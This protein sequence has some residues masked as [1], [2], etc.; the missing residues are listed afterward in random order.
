MGKHLFRNFLILLFVIASQLMIAYAGL[1]VYYRNAFEYGTWIN[2]IYCTGKSVE[3]VNHELAG[4]FT[5][6]GITV[7]DKEWNAYFISAEDIAYQYDFGEAL[8]IYLNRQN[9]W[10][11]VNSFWKIRDDDIRPVISYDEARFDRC[12]AAM[13]FLSEADREDRRVEIEKT[14]QGYELV[15]ERTGVLNAEMA[16][17]VVAAAVRDSETAVSLSDSGCYY[18]MELTEEM[19]NT[20]QL[21]E[22]I[23]VFQ[24]CHITYQ[25]GETLIP[26]DAAV[27]SEWILLEEDGSFALDEG[28]R[29][30]L[31]ENAIADFIAKLAEE[32]DTVGVSREFQA[33]R[34]ELVTIEGGTYGNRLDQETE[35]S[36]LADAF[37]RKVNEIH[38][39]A[40]LQT[41]MRQGKEDIGDTYVE[42]DMGQQMMYYYQNG[43]LEVETPIVT[44]NTSR[45][46]GTPSGVNYVYQ[47]QTNRI[48]RGEGYASHVNF[49]MPVKGNIGIHDASW[50]NSYGGTIYQTNGSH[51]CIN[52]PY[53]AMAKMYEMVEIGTPVVMFY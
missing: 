44:G 1:A 30:Q 13:P 39:P 6:D 16:K 4:Q 34:G 32:Y 15:N 5:Y 11:W 20:L 23:S 21:W 25:M 14:L 36:Y 3:D 8:K 26:L 38:T 18:D 41:A 48:L 27:V 45:R 43:I 35:I 22:Q 29:L 12:F 50:R 19:Q 2:G 7:Y 49:W 17:Q 51:G 52:T 40:Y 10:L 28:G 47:K 31:K 37:E 24:D 53:Q 9:P 33:T 46:M 42:I